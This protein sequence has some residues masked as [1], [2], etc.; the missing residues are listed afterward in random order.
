MHFP[1]SLHLPSIFGVCLGVGLLLRFWSENRPLA[2]VLLVIPSAVG[3]L[4]GFWLSD[5]FFKKPKDK[6]E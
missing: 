1:A 6:D 5:M 2:I 3:I 4:L